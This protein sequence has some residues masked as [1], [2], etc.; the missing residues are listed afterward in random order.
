MTRRLVGATGTG[1]LRYLRYDREQPGRSGMNHN[2]ANLE[3]VLREAHA[4]GRLALVP[5][6]RLNRR[7]NF[8]APADE[9]WGTYF[10]LDASRLVDGAGEH[11]LPLVRRLPPGLDAVTLEPGR[12]MPAWAENWGLVVRRLRVAYFV[13]EVP[14]D[15]LPVARL[16]L[17][18]SARVR[19]LAAPVTAALRAA[20]GGGFAAVHVRRSDRARWPVG[21]LASPER[22]RRRLGAHGVA[23]GSVVF[24][25]SDER[26]PGFWSALAAH[27]RIVRYTAF[28]ALASLVPP[29][30]GAAPN[31]YLLYEVEKV[32]M[33]EA[34]VR[35]ETFPDPGPGTPDADGTLVG[36][37][38]RYA[39]ERSLR[40]GYW[41]Q[42]RRTRLGRLLPPAVRRRIGRALG[43]GRGR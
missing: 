29:Q 2:L 13:R 12:R 32:V 25:L 14:L 21:R 20:A 24:C 42:R 41:L 3:C 26:D 31:N 37:G 34:S 33:R 22:V 39:L 6:L 36:P 27:Y 16:R 30:A 10:D 19:G 1:R 18:P 38:V 5:A 9:R 17:C 23:D 15:G 7:H 40:L 43:K 11:R 8:G 35:L 4:F 28:Q